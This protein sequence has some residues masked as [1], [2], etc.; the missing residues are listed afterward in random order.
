MKAKVG[1]I[2]GGN[3]A[4]AF[5]SGFVDGQSLLPN[6]VSVSDVNGERLK[7]L[8]ETYDVK[9]FNR[10]VDVVLNS[11]VLFLAV[12]PQVMSSVLKEIAKAITPGQIVVSMAAGYPIWKIEKLLGDDKK[13]VRIMPNIIVKVRK[14]VVAFCQN[15]NLFDSDVKIVKELLSSCSTVVDV[16]EKL[17]DGVTALSGSGPAFIFLVIEAL[18]DGGVKVGLPRSTA[19]KLS[20]ETILGS[21]EMV[22]SG[23]H[24][25]V[26]KDK[27][28]SP[29]GTTI[30]GLS[31]LEK[32]RTR[33]ALIEAIEK[34]YKRSIEISKLVEE[35]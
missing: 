33:Y 25:E 12:K 15:F 4:E 14:G 2:G 34:A 3:M 27:V 22:K 17:F 13:I 6:Q 24:P 7:Y 31:A 20:V 35:M 16:D 11:D 10:N 28:T 1:F 23:E 5:I 18:A 9:A 21:A 8:E 32:N 26:L 30:A 29:A 19:L